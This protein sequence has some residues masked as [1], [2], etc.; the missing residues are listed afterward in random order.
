MTCISSQIKKI[1]KADI[2]EK[3]RKTPFAHFQIVRVI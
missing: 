1:R 2:C 3:K